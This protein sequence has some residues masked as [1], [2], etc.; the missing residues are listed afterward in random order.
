MLSAINVIPKHLLQKFSPK[1]KIKPATIKL[2][3]HNGT[4]IPVS[5]KCIGK[6]KLKD[7]TVNVLFIVVDSDSV[8]ILGLNTSVKL[9]LIKQTYQ[10]S[11]NVQFTTP[12]QEEFSLCFGEI[13]CLPRVHHIEIRDDVK[14]VITP[15]RKIPFAL[16]PK[17]KKGTETHGLEIIEEVE[18]PTD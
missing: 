7:R 15:V 9:N 18:K 11:Q 17:L 14:P 5:G 13:G 2:S 1:P 4:S 8:P 16:K 6:M 12:I 3:A 10:I